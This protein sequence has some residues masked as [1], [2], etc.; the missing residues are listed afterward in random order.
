MSEAPTPHQL[1]PPP[2][3]ERDRIFGAMMDAWSSLEGLLRMLFWILLGS[4]MNV[5]FVLFAS[6]FEIGR[7]REVLIGMGRFRLT[8]DEQKALENL[9]ERLGRQAK[10]RNR[11]VH[12]SWTHLV[13]IKDG[14]SQGT[15][16]VIEEWMRV[17]KPTDPHIEQKLLKEPANQKV[18]AD[19][20]F[21]L[22]RIVQITADIHKL[23]EDFS[24][25]YE[26]VM[27]RLYPQGPPI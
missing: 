27:K 22:P 16:L 19:Y 8:E 2:T 11:I 14:P 18:Q 26:S 23:R 12:G 20:H 3:D 9:C 7:L 17:Y 1:T 24:Q 6:G 13:T 4:P 25:F 10:W 15:S 5:A 21:K